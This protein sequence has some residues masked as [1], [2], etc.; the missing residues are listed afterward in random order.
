MFKKI[1]KCLD[2]YE[3]VCKN[4]LN[5]HNYSIKEDEEIILDY[6]NLHLA[7]ALLEDYGDSETVAKIILVSKGR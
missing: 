6:F 2:D 1:R 5:T 7:E 4:I 3:N